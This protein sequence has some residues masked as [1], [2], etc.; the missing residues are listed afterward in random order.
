MAVLFLDS[1]R[2]YTTLPQLNSKWSET[3]LTDATYIATGGRNDGPYVN[4]QNG[5]YARC[6][7]GARTTVIAGVRYRG[8]NSV[9]RWL[10]ILN[11][12]NGDNEVM[13]LYVA[14]GAEEL[15]PAGRIILKDSSGGNFVAYGPLDI[16][17]DKD[18][19]EWH[20]YE[21]KIHCSDESGLEY[22]EV[23]LDGR[24]II[25]VPPDTGMNWGVTQITSMGF[26][27][28]QDHGESELSS[29]DYC[30]F[31]CADTL[32]AVA[33]DF[34]IQ[35]DGGDLAVDYCPALGAG[36]SQQSTISGSAPASTRVGGVSELTPDDD[37]TY[38][39]FAVNQEDLYTIDPS[40]LGPHALPVAMQVLGRRQSTGAGTNTNR[41][42]VRSRLKQ[43]ES[44]DNADSA[45]WR[46]DAF[47]C[48]IDPNTLS[49]ISRKTLGVLQAGMR[50]TG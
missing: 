5:D 22:A 48:S 29:S 33:N 37:V 4:F 9:R 21:V 24:Q 40:S 42:V 16:V 6:S 46:Y 18:P 12:S 7:F 17:D 49:R 15:W 44:V 35:T 38:N 3:S 27:M 31:Y 20:V 13:A 43:L 23:H 1:M 45:A 2:H 41:L 11:F 39:S 19:G 26:G 8:R 14:S 28:F 25:L 34:I 36:S 30:D 10:P 50:K 47:Q 32:G